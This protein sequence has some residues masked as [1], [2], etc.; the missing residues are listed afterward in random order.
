MGSQPA[1]GIV[2][3]HRGIRQH[4][5]ELL[6]IA[7]G[8]SHD[9][10]I[11]LHS[12]FH[13]GVDLP[14]HR[15]EVLLV[16]EDAGVPHMITPVHNRLYAEHVLRVAQVD[17]ERLRHLFH[18]N[19]EVGENCHVCLYQGVIGLGDVEGNTP[20][21]SVYNHLNAV[22]DVVESTD[23]L[24][25]WIAAGGSV[26]VLNPEQTTVDNHHIG[27]VVQREERRQVVH[28]FLDITVVQH[29][30]FRSKFA[31]DKE[32][33][34]A[35]LPG[36]YQSSEKSVEAHAA[37]AFVAPVDILIAAGIIELLRIRLDDYVVVRLF[38][39]INLGALYL[40]DTHRRYVLQQ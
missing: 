7:A 19:K 8:Q 36:I 28:A 18:G 2:L 30:A 39:V 27:V 24:G 37:V 1:D 9:D 22:A 25:I 31:T 4:Q 26:C 33:K 35:E 32:I 38:A 13:S 40:K 17:T 15:P 5:Q 20:V 34:I 11:R 14:R 29:V 21:I 10:V 3:I 6:L 16:I 12:L 23:W